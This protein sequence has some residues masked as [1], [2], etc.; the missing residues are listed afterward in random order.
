MCS[1]LVARWLLT[2]FFK[3]QSTNNSTNYPHTV[4]IVKDGVMHPA[5][6]KMSMRGRGYKNEIKVMQQK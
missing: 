3:W 1:L 4:V 5:H 2:I 6:W